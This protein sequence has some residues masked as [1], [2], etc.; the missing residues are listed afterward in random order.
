MLRS[1]QK[2][3]AVMK[4]LVDKYYQPGDI[5]YDPFVGSYEIGDACLL[6]PLHRRFIFGDNDEGC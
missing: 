4:T 3:V 6:V 2:S 1:E 5:V